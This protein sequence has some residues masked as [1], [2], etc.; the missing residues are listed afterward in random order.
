[1]FFIRYENY[2]SF[3]SGTKIYK[4]R[5][6]I[7]ETDCLYEGDFYSN[8]AQGLGSEYKDSLKKFEGEYINGQPHGKGMTYNETGR[9]EFKGIVK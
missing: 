2:F 5:S 8:R 4:G 6:Y 3:N 1:M 9:V 7:K